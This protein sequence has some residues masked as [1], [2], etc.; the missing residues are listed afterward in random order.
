MGANDEAAPDLNISKE[1][2]LLAKKLEDKT[3]RFVTKSQLNTHIDNLQEILLEK[4]P[5]I[6]HVSSHGNP[7]T[8]N[9]P[10]GLVFEIEDVGLRDIAPQ[11]FA[12]LIGIV[13]ADRPMLLLVPE[14]LL[15][16]RYGKT[17]QH[18]RY[19]RHR[20]ARSD[21]RYRGA[22]VHHCPLLGPCKWF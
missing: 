3:D 16:L 1:F 6:L 19:P 22:E 20:H 17:L 14:C 8:E 7:A 13:V 12:D 21:R 15:W 11:N 4:E 9:S 2:S 10:G 5:T 18:A